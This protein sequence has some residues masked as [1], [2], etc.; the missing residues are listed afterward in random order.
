MT[1]PWERVAVALSAEA[2]MHQRARQEAAPTSAAVVVDTEISARLRGGVE[3]DHPD[4]VAVAVLARPVALDYRNADLAWLAAGLAAAGALGELTDDRYVCD[5]PDGV[6]SAAVVAGATGTD[7][8]LRS[9]SVAATASTHLGPGRVDYAVVV[10]RVAPVDM[11]G[12]RDALIDSLVRHARECARRLDDPVE[13]LAR[14]RACCATLGHRVAISL[15]PN[16]ATRGVATDIA[17]SGG[18]VVRSATGLAETVAVPAL[19]RLSLL[20]D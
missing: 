5:W 9:P 6:R 7:A 11:L 14:Y 2:R 12:S 4:A 17:A 16:G 13:L 3:W 15:A 1:D 20:E 8:T 18:L 10:I 19:R